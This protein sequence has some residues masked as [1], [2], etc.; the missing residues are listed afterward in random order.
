MTDTND[1][2]FSVI[3]MESDGNSN[4]DVNVAWPTSEERVYIS[5]VHRRARA[6]QY[7]RVMEY[8]L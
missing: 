5:E 4:A 3:L 7:R 8:P 2:N 1:Y 6:I